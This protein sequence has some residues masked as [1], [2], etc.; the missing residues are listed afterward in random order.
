MQLE[1][2]SDID[3]SDVLRQVQAQLVE[4]LDKL[5]AAKETLARTEIRAPVS[6]IVVGMTVTTI[7]G[8]IR[9]GET[10]MDIVPTTD[11]I[12]V[13]AKVEPKDADAIRIGQSVS[14]R[15]EGAGT[16][17]APVAKAVVE[18]ISADSLN[19]QRTGAS[20]FE[21]VV[22][23][24]EAHLKEIPRHLL[25]PGLPA[26]V[27]IETGSRTA[28]GYMLAPLSRASFSAMRER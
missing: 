7:G 24:P 9:S 8:V 20:Y 16:R 25:R 5:A 15:L 18:K 1:R 27:L 6:G 10:L 14:V 17:Y 13:N 23:I 11:K 2:Q 21:V 19:D 22:A 26:D 4:L 12:V 3:A 28:F